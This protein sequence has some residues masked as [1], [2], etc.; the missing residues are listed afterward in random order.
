METLKNQ[1][2]SSYT[3]TIDLKVSEYNF[4]CDPFLYCFYREEVFEYYLNPGASIINIMSTGGGP[5]NLGGWYWHNSGFY[6]TNKNTA[7]PLLISPGCNYG[8]INN[9][10]FECTMRNLMVYSNGGIIGA[11]A[12]TNTSEQH[13]NSYVLNRFND[14]IFQD[15]ELTYGEIFKTIKSEL[16]NNYP[17]Y[18]YHYNSLIYFG[19]PSLTPSI[20]KHRSGTITASTTWS[21]NFVID[22]SVTVPT[23]HT[24]TILPGTNLFFKNGSSLIVE[25]GLDARGTSTKY[26]TFNKDNTTHKHRISSHVPYGAEPARL[27]Q[28]DLEALRI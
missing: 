27:E 21:G 28:T 1:H 26:I 3:S 18:E 17:L 9:P 15:E 11:I 2:I 24:L 7:M 5:D 8:E 20:Y 4:G 16:A 13:A 25:G 22:N 14:M 19:D 23:G 10:G 12:P 6:F